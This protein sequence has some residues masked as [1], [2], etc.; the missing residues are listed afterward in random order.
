VRG[1]ASWPRNPATCASAHTL[2]HDE[3]GEGVTDREGPR[4][5]ERRGTR[6]AIAQRL[7]NRARE[8]ERE[9][10]RARA[11]QLV[12]IGRPQRAEGERESAREKATADRQGLP[13]RRRGRAGMLP[14]WAELGCWAAFPFSFSLD[15]LIPFLF[16]FYRVFKFQIQIRFQIQINSNMCNTSKNIL[17]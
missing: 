11:K 17:S 7:A 5:R 3:R 13:V 9:E 15:F 6:G 12:P 8:A 2:V 10:G 1:R 16:L 4:R 14:N